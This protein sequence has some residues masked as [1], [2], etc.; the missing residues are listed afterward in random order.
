MRKLSKHVSDA[1]RRRAAAEEAVTFLGS[2]PCGRVAEARASCSPERY[3]AWKE[4]FIASMA[5]A[6][7]VKPRLACFRGLQRFC[8]DRGF[9][10]W[11][12]SWQQVEEYLHAPS[13]RGGPVV[14]WPVVVSGC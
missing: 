14:Q 6:T 2:W 8:V 7:D 12:L 9:S 13:P 5:G 4:R 3:P 11:E 10:L 1:E